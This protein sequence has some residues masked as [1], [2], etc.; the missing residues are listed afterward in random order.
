MGPSSGIREL[1]W[2]SEWLF[3]WIKI[4]EK[5]LLW[6]KVEIVGKLPQ[7]GFLVEEGKFNLSFLCV[8]EKTI[9]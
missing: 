2:F 6:V 4:E 5:G 7:L 1:G 9:S 3:A 8:E